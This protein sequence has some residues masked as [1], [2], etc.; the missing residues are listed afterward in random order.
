MFRQYSDS[1]PCILHYSYN[2]LFVL[3]V[4]R[5]VSVIE[6]FLAEVKCLQHWCEG[7]FNADQFWHYGNSNEPSNLLGRKLLY[8]CT[9]WIPYWIWN[10]IV[11]ILFYFFLTKNKKI[12]DTGIGQT[13]IGRRDHKKQK[14][15]KLHAKIKVPQTRPALCVLSKKFLSLDIRSRIGSSPNSHLRCAITREMIRSKRSPLIVNCT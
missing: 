9:N 3:S 10:W 4:L 8:Y 7:R 2:L 11:L 15:K 1:R 14:T 6:A 13:E 12:S 5:S